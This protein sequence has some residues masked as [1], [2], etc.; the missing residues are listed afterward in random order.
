MIK[1]I[2]F[3]FS[4]LYAET[5]REHDGTVADCVCKVIPTMIVDIVMQN[6]LLA[7]DEHIEVESVQNVKVMFLTFKNEKN[8]STLKA[9]PANVS[10]LLWGSQNLSFH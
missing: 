2:Y 8:K 7:P 9:L 3:D 10:M 1:H 5:L 4:I 6:S